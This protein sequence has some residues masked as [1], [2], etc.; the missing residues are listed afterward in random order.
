MS[1]V[2]DPDLAPAGRLKI[3]WAARHMPVLSRI[4]DGLLKEKPFRGLN[5]GMCLHLEAKTACLA[6]ALMEGGATVSVA[7]SNPLSTQDEVAAALA[8]Q[9]ANVYAWRGSSPE[10]YCSFL[11][12]VV[13]DGPNL[14]IDDGGDLVAML[15]GV[16]PKRAESVIGGCEETT[17]GIRRLRAME[18]E[19]VLRFPMVA[20][21]NARCKYLFDNRYGSGQSV[22]DGIVRTTNLLVAGK[23][24]VV[25]GYGWC[26]KGVAMRAAGLGA[27]VVICE[28]DPVRANEALSDGYRVMHSL[29][30]AT[31]GDIFVTV[32]GCRDVLRAEHFNRM[33]DGAILANAGHFDVEISLPDL[34]ALSS[35]VSRPRPGVTEYAMSDG[36]RL[37]LLAEGRLVNLGV[38]DG[39]PVEI[40]DMSFAIQ[41]LSLK[42]VTLEGKR[43]GSRVVPVPPEIDE[44]VAR[45]RLEALGVRIDEL[46][47]EQKQYLASWREQ[48]TASDD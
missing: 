17:T 21:N 5:V 15:H 25:L 26:G 3:D 29:D 38:A 39:H 12:M 32:T 42:Y 30:A 4:R 37:Y 40:M 23:T 1:I 34:A 20:V 7:G 19:G 10:E 16:G 44:T 35:S 11:R 13:E 41:A 46:T 2:R 27:S 9:G 18:R 28:V 43:L 33:K 22:W 8:D 45:L 24:V 31:I 48:E 36:R 6:I 14:V 47:E